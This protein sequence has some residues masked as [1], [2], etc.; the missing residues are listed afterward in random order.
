MKTKHG[1][2]NGMQILDLKYSSTV[3]TKALSITFYTLTPFNPRPVKSNHHDDANAKII[4][5]NT[6]PA[7]THT[8]VSHSKTS[9]NVRM[10]LPDPIL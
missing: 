1:N 5:I 3:S 2:Q 10:H 6:R 8:T 9:I 4:Y 7:T